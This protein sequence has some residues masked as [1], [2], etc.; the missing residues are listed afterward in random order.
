[1]MLACDSELQRFDALIKSLGLISDGLQRMSL[2]TL[3]VYTWNL[4]PKW[5]WFDDLL[6]MFSR[7]DLE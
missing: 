5:S 1:M 2:P 7:L 4:C 3:K 6:S